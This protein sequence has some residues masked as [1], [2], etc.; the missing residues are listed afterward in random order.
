VQGTSKIELALVKPVGISKIFFLLDVVAP[1]DGLYGAGL[2]MVLAG[3]CTARVVTFD[4]LGDD[5]SPDAHRTSSPK[6]TMEKSVASLQSMP[7]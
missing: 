1:S 6:T 4:N 2:T 3:E 5:S 7:G